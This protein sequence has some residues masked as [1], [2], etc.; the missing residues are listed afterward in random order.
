MVQMY[1]IRSRSLKR[2]N[3]LIK[4]SGSVLGTT[5][6][7]LETLMKSRILHKIMKIKSN[8]GPGHPLRN[9]I[10]HQQCPQSEAYSVLLLHRLLQ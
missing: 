10:L 8:P 4:K 9:I 6:E 7:L 5:V 3:N 1:P 2:V